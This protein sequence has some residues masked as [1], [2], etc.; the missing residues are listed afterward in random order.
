MI[1][2]TG[3]S[4]FVGNHLIPE[5]VRQGFSVNCLVLNEKEAEKVKA[6]GVGA[7]IGNV[8]DASSIK[9]SAKDAEAIIHMVAILRERGKA[10]FEAVNV[11]GTENMLK[12]AKDASVKRFIHMGILGANPNPKYRYLHSKWKAMQ[13]VGK[14]GLEY[15]IF[16]P[17]VMFGKGAG[18]TEALL[19]SINMFPFIAPVA[20]SGK[21]MLQPIWVGDVVSCLI[22]AVKGKCLNETCEIGGP[23]QLTYKEM[24][25]VVMEASSIKKPKVHIPIPLMRPAVILMEKL[26]SNP[27]ITKDELD[28]LGLDNLT[29]IDAV[30]KQFG[31]MPMDI[32]EGLKYLSREN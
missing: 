14:S 25:Q 4:G 27:P 11:K 1:L 29:E 12:E 18:F 8:A 21:T 26:S 3:G 9:G 7:T 2:V 22:E 30:Q 13:K 17:S 19:R 10:T 31:F 24:M 15:T 20:G 32:K 5:L 23:E 28:A 16:K 6:L